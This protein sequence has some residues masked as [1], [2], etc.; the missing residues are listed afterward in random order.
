MKDQGKE[1]EKCYS[2]VILMSFTTNAALDIM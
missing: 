1:G 2:Q